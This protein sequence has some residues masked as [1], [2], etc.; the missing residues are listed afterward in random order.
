MTTD[1]IKTRMEIAI[2]KIKTP[3]LRDFA[4][5]VV[6]ALPAKAWEREASLKYHHID[7]HGTGGNIL[8]EIRTAIVA[9]IITRVTD[10]PPVQKD[11]IYTAALLHDVCRHGLDAESK[12]TLKD[13][14]QQ[15]R[16][17]VKEHGLTSLWS[18][19]VCELI[20]THMSKWG[21]PPYVPELDPKD[22]VV[23]ADFI[24]SQTNVR[25]TD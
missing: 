22:I 19:A 20:D 5:K 7:E 13:H 25:I 4:F 6:E 16:V 24:T 1:E 21:V 2:R 8:H 17:F 18:D 11:L 12:Y 9:E 10:L 23:L 3:E 14:A 15:V